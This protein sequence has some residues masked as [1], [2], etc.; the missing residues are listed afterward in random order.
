MN[1]MFNCQESSLIEL[2]HNEA[3]YRMLK[4]RNHVRI[5][6][7]NPIKLS[8]YVKD[9]PDDE[10]EILDRD[11]VNIHEDECFVRDAM[12]KPDMRLTHP[13]DVFVYDGYGTSG[14]P[15]DEYGTFVLDG[16]TND[17]KSHL[18][19]TRQW[20][21][22]ITKGEKCCWKSVLDK[23]HKGKTPPSNALIIIDRYLFS[24]NP[25]SQTDYKNGIRNVF[26]LLNELLP[27][28]FSGEYHV[29]IVF[30]DT[31]ISNGATI[32][33]ISRGLQKIKMQLNRNFIPTIELLTVN[34]N[35]DVRMFSETHDRKI[36]SNY[37]M[38][39]CTHGFSAVLPSAERRDDVDYI[40]YGNGAWSQTIM[41]EGV[42]A[43]INAEDEDLDVSALP[44]RTTEKTVSYLSDYLRKLKAGRTGFNYVCN[45]NNKTPIQEFRNRL[46]TDD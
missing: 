41:Y 18:Y 32:N 27:Q 9:Q 19:L 11:G 3:W 17:P 21:S 29:L 46:I 25:E 42:Y 4:D 14:K 28:T 16:S 22:L 45:G 20:K 7:K 34:K 1:K 33:Q 30:D 38:I 15:Q 44:I 10:W 12:F 39:T 43:G 40:G 6:G 31:A 8:G 37:Y 26:G 2:T 13:C 5:P 24:Y 23:F 36:I 35:V